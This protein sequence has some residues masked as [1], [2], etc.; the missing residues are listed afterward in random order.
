MKEI[1]V[2][3]YF[4]VITGAPDRAPIGTD[5]CVCVNK[6]WG[7]IWIYK[8]W[9]NYWRYAVVTSKRR[10]PELVRSPGWCH[11]YTSRKTSASAVCCYPRSPR[12][13]LICFY[14]NRFVLRSTIATFV[15]VEHWSLVVDGPWPHVSVVN[16]SCMS[17][18]MSMC[19]KL[20]H[21]VVVPEKST[22]QPWTISDIYSLTILLY[23]CT[24]K[25][26][27]VKIAKTNSA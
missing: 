5:V 26:S 25:S 18:C 8:V 11:S 27:L 17:M 14:V 20:W 10:H 4:C 21:N 6:V 7:S 19:L 22:S 13:S 3:A 1:S 2:Q 23:I 15:L 24:K 16:L 9:D 12:D